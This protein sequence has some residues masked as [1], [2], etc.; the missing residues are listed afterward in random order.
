MFIVAA[1]MGFSTVENMEY[2]MAGDLV[3][4]ASPPLQKLAIAL[5]RGACTQHP[6]TAV[7]AA[8]MPDPGLLPLLPVVVSFPIH[9]IC[10]GFTGVMLL[11][12]EFGRGTPSFFLFVL[13]PAI[14]V[15][16]S[17]DAVVRTTPPPIHLHTHWR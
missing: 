12:R 3:G 4:S 5:L 17:F 8:R 1:A 10:A 14:L 9:S 2:T 11:R 7:V 15:H 6:R 13:G 16:G